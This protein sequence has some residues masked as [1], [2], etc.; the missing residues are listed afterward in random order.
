MNVTIRQLHVAHTSAQSQVSYALKSKNNPVVG[1]NKVVIHTFVIDI[2]GYYH[3]D[4]DSYSIHSKLDENGGVE[5]NNEY[6]D[7]TE[8]MMK[9]VEPILDLKYPRRHLSMRGSLNVV[10]RK[11]E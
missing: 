4:E 5:G 3:A 9:Q 11:N 10:T 6:T 7:D 1:I 2:I 8:A